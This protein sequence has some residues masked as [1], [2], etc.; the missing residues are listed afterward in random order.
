MVA[1]T[2]M[3]SEAYW[4]VKFRAGVYDAGETDGLYTNFGNVAIGASSSPSTSA[5]PNPVN[6]AANLAA[7]SGGSYYG[8][9]RLDS[10]NPAP[11]NYTVAMAVGTLYPT[12]KTVWVS[13]WSPSSYL[14]ATGR[15]LPTNYIVTVKKGEDVLATWDYDDLYRAADPGTTAI[16]MVGF[17]YTFDEN[18][19]S[20]AGVDMDLF[21]ITVEP[22]PE[23]GSMLALASGLVGMAGFALRRRRT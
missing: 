11:Y 22:V 1:S 4:V 9:Q 10:D 19:D 21:S 17:R 15:A 5:A 2:A 3:A 12:G 13:A 16:G 8:T 20:W 23:P 7:T 6:T 18:N 14:G